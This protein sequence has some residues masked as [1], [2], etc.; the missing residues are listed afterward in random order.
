[1]LDVDAAQRRGRLIEQEQPRPS[2]ERPRDL[3]E[4][5]LPYG[6]LFERGF[7]V[8]VGK[9]HGIEKR[10]PAT[11]VVRRLPKKTRIKIAKLKIIRNGQK[12]ISLPPS[13]NQHASVS[14]C[15]FAGWC[16][17]IVVELTLVFGKE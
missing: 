2:P 9:S 16:G 11:D 13:V 5:A 7:R 1:M 3:D 15:T 8:D 6:Q 10:S 14:T 12:N 4:L 17:R